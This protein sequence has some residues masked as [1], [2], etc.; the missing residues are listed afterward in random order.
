ML[1]KKN[2]ADKKAID[3]IFEKGKFLNSTHLTFKFLILPG[4]KKQ[5]SFIVPKNIAKKAVERNKLRRI[6]YL[7]LEKNLKYFPAGI[8]GTFVFKKRQADI[9]ILENEIKNILGKIN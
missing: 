3:K 1:P 6:G 4:D 7:V 2:R 9:L 8:S 5:I